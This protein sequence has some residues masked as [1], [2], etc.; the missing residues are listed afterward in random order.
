MNVNS[1]YMILKEPEDTYTFWIVFIFESDN[2]EYYH[3]NSKEVKN[4]NIFHYEGENEIS[5]SEI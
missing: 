2:F 3:D 4:E 1:Q 5:D